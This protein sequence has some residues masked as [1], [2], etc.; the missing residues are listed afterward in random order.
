[1]VQ[2]NNSWSGV[3]RGSESREPLLGA[4]AEPRKCVVLPVCCSKAQGEQGLN[5]LKLGVVA[6]VNDHFL[7]MAVKSSTALGCDVAVA[8]EWFS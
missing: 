1:M 3:S 2:P 7:G 8:L 5:F 6:K 4:E